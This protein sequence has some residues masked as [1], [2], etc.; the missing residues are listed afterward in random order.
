MKTAEFI[1]AAYAAVQ[2]LS[3]DGDQMHRRAVSGKPLTVHRHGRRKVPAGPVHGGMTELVPV[4]AV[5]LRVQGQSIDRGDRERFFSQAEAEAFACAVETALSEMP[6]PVPPQANY[7]PRPVG[8]P[9]ELASGRA[10]TLYLDDESFATAKS[11]G[12]GS[13]SEGIRA[14]LKIAAA[15]IAG[16]R[17]RDWLASAQ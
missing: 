10:R 3:D 5:S 7:P 17:S 14:A 4:W 8:R 6:P 1:S 13:A 11:L 9:Q 2:A 16:C 15:G 12:N